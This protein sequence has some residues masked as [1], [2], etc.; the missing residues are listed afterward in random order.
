MLAFSDV[1]CKAEKRKYEF[2]K[3][4]ITTFKPLQLFQIQ[5]LSSKM[6]FCFF[7]LLTFQIKYKQSL[8]M[9]EKDK[10]LYLLWKR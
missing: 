6:I 4:N 7:R 10:Y 8:F 2:A 1:K 5:N 9:F 3:Q